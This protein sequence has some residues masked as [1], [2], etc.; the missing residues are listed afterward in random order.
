[1]W[2][3]CNDRNNGLIHSLLIRG[4]LFWNSL[5]LSKSQVQLNTKESG[6]AN[7]FSESPKNS[8]SVDLPFL[9]FLT[10]KYVSSNL[11]K[12]NPLATDKS[13]LV[14]V[15]TTYAGLIL[16]SGTPLILNGPVTRIVSA[17]CLSMTTRFPR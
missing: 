12:L 8:A 4:P 14:L 1:M 16:L 11:S 15:A 13:T 9:S 5:L 10:L 3:L 7:T 6:G 17:I 2:R